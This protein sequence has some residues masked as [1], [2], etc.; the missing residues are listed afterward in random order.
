[1]VGRA[2]LLSAIFVLLSL[3]SYQKLLSRVDQETEELRNV[4]NSSGKD[5]DDENSAANT[6]RPSCKG[7]SPFCYNIKSL[8]IIKN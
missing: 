7:S 6:P 1:M 8:K 2:E 5:D 4:R 3:I